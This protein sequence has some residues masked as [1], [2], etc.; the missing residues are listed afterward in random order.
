M[1]D[2]LPVNGRDG[3]RA[4]FAEMLFR[5]AVMR[6]LVF[7]R[8][9]DTGLVIVPPDRIDVGG[10][11]GFRIP[12]VGSDYERCRENV[13]PSVVVTDAGDE[14]KSNVSTA[15]LPTKVIAAVC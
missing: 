10:L 4:G 14:L 7:Y 5:P 6:Q 2:L 13:R 9:G 8:H 15:L 11:A 12:P 3:K 1:D